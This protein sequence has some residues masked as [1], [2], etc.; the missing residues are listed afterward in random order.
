MS[1][2]LYL[3]RHAKAEALAP[4][5]EDFDRPLNPRGVR[6]SLVI[7]EYMRQKGYGAPQVLCS[8][9]ARTRETLDLLRARHQALGKAHFD[10]S[11]YLADMS[12]LLECIRKIAGKSG[13][14]LLVG[15]NPG[16][17]ELALDLAA[18]RASADWL[19]MHQK[20]PTGALASFEVPIENWAEIKL[21]QAKLLEF[22]WPK[23]I[24]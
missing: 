14:L 6:A 15:H 12:G 19:A 2:R 23:S 8:P 9:A 1:R 16:L 5:G 7:G 17:H 11:L 10:R 3:L 4:S 22:I 21:G 24:I 20:F 13:A 18:E